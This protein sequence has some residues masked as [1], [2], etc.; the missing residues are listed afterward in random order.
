MKSETSQ[1]TT[2]KNAYQLI[3]HM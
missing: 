2:T 3:Q 1:Q